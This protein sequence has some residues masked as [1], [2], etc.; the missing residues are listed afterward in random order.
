LRLEFDRDPR[1]Q[2]RKDDVMRTS[3]NTV[4]VT[5]GG[6]G[7]GLA[8]TE[9]LVRRGNE[10]IICGRRKNLLK[11]AQ[12]RLPGIHFR[13]CDLS[14]AR[15]RQMLTDWLMS[16]FKQLNVL[17]NN[18]GIQR[19]VDF[20]KGS[21]DLDKAEQE[22]GTNLMAPIDLSARLLPH[23]RNKKEAAI[24]NISSGL[25]YTPLAAVPVYCA[26]KAAL[27]SLSL[28]LRYQ[29]RDTSVKVFEIA[30]PMVAT[31]LSGRRNRPQEGG[32]LMSAET[33]A[34]G[35]MKALEE[36]RHQVALGAAANLLAQRE[37]LFSA[38]NP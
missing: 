31:E 5:G 32:T 38:I 18:A 7:I 4:L 9:A 35:I 25:A 33:V 37:A 3:G 10:V 19:Q 26:T 30:P 13:V 29:L 11:A 23:L 16:E 14:K 22:V 21:R 17:V 8:L 36:N 28:S 27:H 1:V 15:A 20:L 12:D 6:S 2:R 24:V 34:E